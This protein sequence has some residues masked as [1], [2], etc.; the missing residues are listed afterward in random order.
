MNMSPLQARFV[1]EYLKDL[2][3][4]KAAI[5]AGY[6]EGSAESKGYALLKVPKVREAIDDAIRRRSERVEIR[7]DD[8][9]RELLRL[10]TVDI[11]QAFDEQGRL[12]PMHEMPADVRRAIASVET[13]EL[14]GGDGRE[15]VEIGQIRKIKFW[16]KTKALEM[17]GRHLKLFTDRVEHS[18]SMTLEQLVLASGEKNAIDGISSDGRNSLG[19]G[20]SLP[21]GHLDSIA[22]PAERAADSGDGEPTL[23]GVEELEEGILDGMQ[24]QE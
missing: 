10:A 1:V 16:D 6:A 23:G 17:L 3:P 14:Y 19:H 8:V 9:L 24:S 15:R 2:S 21:S 13:I 4:T 11:G 12:K 22:L 5:R 7:T 18:V 20:H